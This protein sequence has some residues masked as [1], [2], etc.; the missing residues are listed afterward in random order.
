MRLLFPAQPRPRFILFYSQKAYDETISELSTK[1]TIPG[2]GAGKRRRIPAQIILSHFGAATVKGAVL[3]ELTESAIKSAIE[4]V[5]INPIGQAK[6]LD[7]AE[8]LVEALIPGEPLT[9]EV[10]VDV[11]PQVQFKGDYKGFKVTV[12]KVSGLFLPCNE[13]DLSPFTPFIT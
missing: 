5:A 4:R 6:L 1:A 2:F 11:W 9:I 8:S 12:N 7:S 10:Q 13:Y 3:E